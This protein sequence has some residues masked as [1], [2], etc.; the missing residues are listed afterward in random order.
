MAEQ[1]CEST[2]TT[3]TASAPGTGRTGRFPRLRWKHIVSAT[4]LGMAV[5][6]QM[7]DLHA[8]QWRLLMWLGVAI[9][10]HLVSKIPG[11]GQ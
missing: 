11:G 8:D 3:P 4:A 9:S 10:G 6:V 5:W 1:P 7:H 2:P